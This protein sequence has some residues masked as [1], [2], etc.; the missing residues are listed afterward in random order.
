MSEQGLLRGENV[1][2][3]ELPDFFSKEMDDEGPSQCI[4]MVIIK[5]RG[6][7]NRYGKPFFLVT[8]DMQMCGYAQY[9]LWLYFSSIDFK[10]VM[11][12]F[13]IFPVQKTGMIYP[14]FALM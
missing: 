7:T 14:C 6:K 5:G 4:A 3:L 8:I 1:R 11:N 9:L 10:S 13:Q 12:H 2:D